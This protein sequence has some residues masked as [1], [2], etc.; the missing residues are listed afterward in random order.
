MSCGS[1]QREQ[2]G[3]AGQATVASAAQCPELKWRRRYKKGVKKFYFLCSY[4]DLMDVYDTKKQQEKNQIAFYALFT[5]LLSPSFSLPLLL[6]HTHTRIVSVVW[7]AM[8][9]NQSSQ[10][11]GQQQL[12]P[13]SDSDSLLESGVLRSMVCL[14]N[15]RTID[16]LSGKLRHWHANVSGRLQKR[17]IVLAFLRRRRWS[18]PPSPRVE[19]TKWFNFE[20]RK[21]YNYSITHSVW[22][23]GR[24]EG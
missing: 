7:Q 14:I 6:P 9:T 2:E 8:R 11:N 16:M 4:Y 23:C 1:W 10:Q 24:K 12:G 17:Q 3:G 21:L 22:V 5:L 13:D 20:W 19:S 18:Y 15:S